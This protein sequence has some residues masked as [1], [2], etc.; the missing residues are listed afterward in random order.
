M[1]GSRLLSSND[2][3]AGM[4]LQCNCCHQHLISCL[5]RTILNV[6]DSDSIGVN[7]CHSVGWPGMNASLLS[8]P[9][10]NHYF[11]FIFFR[12]SHNHL[13][14]NSYIIDHLFSLV[15]SDMPQLHTYTSDQMLLF[16]FLL[17]VVTWYTYNIRSV[18]KLRVDSFIIYQIKLSVW[19]TDNVLLPSVRC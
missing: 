5:L 11:F 14:H 4:M 12:F 16:S 8:Q 15:C 7:G 13:T 6:R 10:H 9:G 3:G 1:V 2:K 17:A 19:K 18:S